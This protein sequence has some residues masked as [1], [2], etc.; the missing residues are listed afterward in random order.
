MFNHVGSKP[1]KCEECNY[2]S[3]YKKD[4]IRRSGAA[5]RG[6]EVRPGGGGER[7]R[8][9]GVAQRR[10]KKPPRP[11]GG[12]KRRVGVRWFPERPTRQASPS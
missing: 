9:S 12:T 11:C 2:T 4:V 5:V 8:G 3:V 6:A 7:P 1:Y 10:P